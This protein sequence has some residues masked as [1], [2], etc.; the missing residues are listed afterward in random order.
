MTA[1]CHKAIHH[2]QTRLLESPTPLSKKEPYLVCFMYIVLYI[3][4]FL[5]VEI[6]SKSN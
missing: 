2:E 5:H 3:Y 6:C 4:S 1:V